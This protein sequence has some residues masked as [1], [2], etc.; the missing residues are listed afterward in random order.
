MSYATRQ[1]SKATIFQIKKIRHLESDLNTD[2][3]IHPTVLAAMSQGEAGQLI[4]IL[5]KRLKAKDQERQVV[6]F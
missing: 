5:Y 2:I 3:R 1:L 6:L 4:N